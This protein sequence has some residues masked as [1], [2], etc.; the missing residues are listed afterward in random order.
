MKKGRMKKVGIYTVTYELMK[1]FLNLDDD[2]KI[3]DVGADW[4]YRK[5]DSFAVKVSGPSMPKV[6][7]GECMTH[8]DARR[9]N[10][11]KSS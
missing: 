10:E 11:D 4:D 3:I 5:Y 9:Q 8:F 1:K 7:E 2:H 6:A